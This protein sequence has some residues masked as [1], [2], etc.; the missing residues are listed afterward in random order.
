MPRVFGTL[1]EAWGMPVGDKAIHNEGLAPCIRNETLEVKTRYCTEMVAQDG[2]FDDNEFNVT[3]ANVLHAGRKAREYEERYGIKPK[4]AQEHID[5]IDEHGEPVSANPSMGYKRGERIRMRVSMLYDLT[6]SEH[7]AEARM[8]REL[9]EI[10]AGES[11]RLL[12]DEVHHIL[13]PLGIKPAVVDTYITH[14]VKSGRVSVERM[15]K[16]KNIPD[17]IR[18]ALLMPPNHPRKMIEVVKF[19]QDHPLDVEEVK[20]RIEKDGLHVDSVWEDYGV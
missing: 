16:T 3:R 10:V 8:A 1:M 11:N 19:V 13:E 5:F 9:Q 7:P 20:G 4:I 18:W 12:D 17:T 14:Y 6:F 15:A 2:C